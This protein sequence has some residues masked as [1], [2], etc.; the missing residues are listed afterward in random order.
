MFQSVIVFGVATV[1]FAL[2]HWM[3]LSVLALAVL[4]PPTSSAW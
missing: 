4:A 1:V 2:S 3:W